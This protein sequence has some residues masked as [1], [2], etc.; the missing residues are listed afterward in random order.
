MNK[1]IVKKFTAF[2]AAIMCMSMAV[3]SAYA[4][5]VLVEE[6]ERYVRDVV[7]FLPGDVNGDG[8]VNVTDITL[9]VAHF[10]GVRKL[11]NISAADFDGDGFITLSDINILAA[12][13]KGKG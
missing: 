3:V 1:V 10:K 2:T 12:K 6:T 8:K 9:A 13:V 5:P 7:E 11:N 4:S